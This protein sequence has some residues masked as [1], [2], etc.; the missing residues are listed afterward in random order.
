[1]LFRQS[2]VESVSASSFTFSVFVIPNAESLSVFES[3]STP[4][5]SMVSTFFTVF[6][7]NWPIAASL[8]C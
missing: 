6:E 1:M 7:S 5:F 2:F 3:F 4:L 8:A